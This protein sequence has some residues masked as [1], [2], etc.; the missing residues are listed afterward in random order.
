PPPFLALA[1]AETDVLVAAV[2]RSPHPARD[3]ILDAA[4]HKP[5]GVVGTLLG[6]LFALPEEHPAHVSLLGHLVLLISSRPVTGTTVP[7]SSMFSGGLGNS[8]RA[9]GAWP[10]AATVSWASTSP[11]AAS[12]SRWVR[13]TWDSSAASS[14]REG[15]GRLTQVRQSHRPVSGLG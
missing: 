7:F 5:A 8:S 11:A 10:T 12:A 2:L 14:G 9:P 4:D 13:S 3:R 6:T 15:D 1:D